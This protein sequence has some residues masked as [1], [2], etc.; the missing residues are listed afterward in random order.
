[1]QANSCWTEAP[2]IGPGPRW[3]AG[4]RRR[5]SR[6]GRRSSTGAAGSVRNRRRAERGAG[7]APVGRERCE[8]PR[9][10]CGGVCVRAHVHERTR[11]REERPPPPPPAARLIRTHP[12]DAPTSATHLRRLHLHRTPTPPTARLMRTHT[13]S[14][15][16]THTHPGTAYTHHGHPAPM[17]G[18]SRSQD[19][20]DRI[21]HTGTNTPSTTLWEP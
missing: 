6:F 18:A 7:S 4:A 15:L 1:M 17:T 14:P 10:R 16:R 2:D 11:G 5:S 9:W 12:A 21:G 3:T 20:V 19:I 8:G 13:P